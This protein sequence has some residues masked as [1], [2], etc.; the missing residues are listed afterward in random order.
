MKRLDLQGLRGLSIL[1]VLLFH[2]FGDTFPNG[3]IGVDMLFVLSGYLMTMILGS[4]KSLDSASNQQFYYRRIKRIVPLFMFTI[5]GATLLVFLLF[6]PTFISINCDSAFTSMFLFKNVAESLAYFQKMSQANDLFVHLWSICVAA[7]FYLLYPLLLLTL[8]RFPNYRIHSLIAII[9]LSFRH[10]ATSDPITSF[11]CVFARLWQFAFGALSFYTAECFDEIVARPKREF[12]LLDQDYD[13]DEIEDLEV[14]LEKREK[15]NSPI[16]HNQWQFNILVTAT[17]SCLLI[18][19]AYPKALEPIALRMMVTVITGTL[20]V[21]GKFVECHPLDNK[22]LV[23]LGDIS[24]CLY[25]VHWPVFV[26]AKHNFDER[27]L[28]YA[29]FALISIILSSLLVETLETFHRRLPTTT[30]LALLIGVLY[31]ATLTMRFV[32]PS[33]TRFN[34]DDVRLSKYLERDVEKLDFSDISRDNAV[35]LN[36]KWARDEAD[37]NRPPNCEPSTSEHGYCEFE[38][39]RLNGDLTTLI[40]GNSFAPNLADL[41]YKIAG[42]FSKKIVKFS[43]P[44]CAVLTINEPNCRPVYEQFIK[45]ANTTKPD[46]MFILDNNS[47]LTRPIATDDFVMVE[48]QNTL[49]IYEEIVSRRIYHLDAM[50]APL[51]PTLAEFARLLENGHQLTQEDFVID[52]RFSLGQLRVKEL[53]KRCRTCDVIRVHDALNDKSFD[54]ATSLAYFYDGGHLTPMAKKIIWPLFRNLTADF[55][56][57]SMIAG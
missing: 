5:F 38:A 26:Y 9:I 49:R 36:K 23:Y 43:A 41:I 56:N 40:I 20:I 13:I 24:Y 18:L 50:C 6:P 48:A 51:R 37:S 27:F 45:I 46:V 55:R 53:V 15:T 17:I 39:S 30:A 12:L 35:I 3:Y 47:K 34:E 25:L 16:E 19:S 54:E 42:D 31:L 10:H 8:N 57:M 2:Y 11:Y 7:Q 1:A 14:N 52:Y 44:D 29:S 4:S 33:N 22:L 21:A 32:K 28:I